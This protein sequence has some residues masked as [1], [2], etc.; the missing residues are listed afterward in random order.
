M[1]QGL[2]GELTLFLIELWVGD[3]VR[4]HDLRRYKRK[5]RRLLLELRVVGTCRMDFE[6]ALVARGFLHL[7][8]VGA[9]ILLGV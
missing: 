7:S 2:I 8:H 3:L 5:H 9:G 4:V 6:L 1:M